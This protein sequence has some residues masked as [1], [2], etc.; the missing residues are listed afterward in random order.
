MD[1]Q[2]QDNQLE[3]IYN[4]SVLIQDVAWKTSWEQWMIETGGERGS[5]GSVLAA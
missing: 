1:K 2:K 4:S 3:P 5:G